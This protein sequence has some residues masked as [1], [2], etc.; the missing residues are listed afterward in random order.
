MV[1]K[2][3]EKNQ[4]RNDFIDDLN[5][6]AMESF[7][8][9]HEEPFDVE[10][11]FSADVANEAK[12]FIFHP[13]QKLTENPDGSLTVKFKAGGKMEIDWFYILGAIV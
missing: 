8:A 3:Q 6:Y 13:K 12:N 2:K 10:W 4:K 11:L 9:F 1:R 7:G 5:E